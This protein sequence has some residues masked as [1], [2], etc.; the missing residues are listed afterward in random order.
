[1]SG[2]ATFLTLVRPG[3]NTMTGVAEGGSTLVARLREPLRKRHARAEFQRAALA[4][5]ADGVLWATVLAKQGSG[6]LRGVAEA[7]ALV[8]IPEGEQQF[9]AG[10]VVAVLPLP[11]WPA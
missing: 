7:N 10:R 11:G 2:I 6:M 4:C 1:M 8:V 5:D 3:L 9:D